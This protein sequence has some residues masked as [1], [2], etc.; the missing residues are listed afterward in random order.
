MP[1]ADRDS[2]ALFYEDAGSGGPP[3]VFVHGLGTHNQYRRQ[4]E[5]FSRSHRV[6]APDLPGYGRS[7]APQREYSIPAFADDITWLCD[8]LGLPAPVIVGHSMA[9]GIAVEIAARRPGL[10]AAIV[11]LDPVP[12]AATPLFRERLTP[13]AEALKGPNYRQA[14]RRYAESRMFRPTDEADL[15]AQVV[16]E[17]CAQPQH[18]VAP[19]IA[20]I[21]AWHGERAASL[22]RVPVLLITGDGIPSDMARTREIL[23]GLELGRAVGA[24]HFAHLIVADQVNAMIERFLLVSGVRG[25]SPERDAPAAVPVTDPGGIR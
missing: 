17:M 3:I 20:S 2:A 9:A 5:H 22:V 21:L 6:I 4:I 11:L 19:T 10:P 7:D 14:I 1:I 24:G 18:V 13:F 8:Q 16:D 25:N 15:R 23:P 12:I